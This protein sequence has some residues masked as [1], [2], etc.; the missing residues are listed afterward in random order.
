M[1]SEVWGEKVDVLRAEA[2]RSRVKTF[3]ES[4][5]E[6]VKMGHFNGDNYS[7]VQAGWSMAEVSLLDIG[8][9]GDG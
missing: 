1:K 3:A 7:L 9:R 6:R 8:S 4:W 5:D 2:P